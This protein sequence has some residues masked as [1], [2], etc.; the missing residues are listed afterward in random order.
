RGT[1]TGTGDVVREVLDNGVRVLVMRDPSVAVVAM[2][3][4]WPGGT[5]LEDDATSG[6]TSLLASAITRGC[7]DRDA[8]AFAAAVDDLAGGIAGVGGRNSFGLRAEWLADGWR[9]G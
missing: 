1:G 4:V 7:G 8:A 5:R 6:T 2:R 3:A 9:D